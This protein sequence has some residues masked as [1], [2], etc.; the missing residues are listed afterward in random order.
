RR[1]FDRERASVVFGA[2]GGT[3]L[4]MAYSF[5]A[6]FP[7]YFGRLPS[8]LDE[9]LP[10]LTEDSFAGVL[11][12]VIAGRI[13]NRL[14]LG[15]VNFTIDAA[16]ASSLAALDA[17]CKELVAGSSDLV[18]CGGAD[19]HNGIY[20][21][22]MF[23][24][25]HALSPTGR[26]RSFDAAADGIA[27][28]EGVACVALKRLAD[29]E[30][31]GDRI[32]AVIDAVAGSSDGRSLG[33]TAPR[34]EGQRR[35]LERAY[36]A[37]GVNPAEVGLI[38]AHGTGTVV[39]DRT[40]LSALNDLFIEA[41]AA[42]ASCALGSVKSQIGHTKCAAGLAA[43]VKV[44]AALHTGVRPPTGP[45]AEP[46]PGWQAETSPFFFD[47]QARPWP[48]PPEERHAGVSAFGFGGTNFHAVLS[49]YGGA[50]QPAH[51]QEEWPAELFCLRG[52]DLAGAQA[53]AGRLAGAVAANDAAG[54]PWR[55]CDLAAYNAGVQ[56]APSRTPFPE[57]ADPPPAAAPVQL[58]FVAIN[59]DDLAA[60]LAAATDGGGYGVFGREDA[61]VGKVAFLFP[62]QGSQRPG[63]LSD[64]FVAFPRL[65]RHLRGAAARYA[66]LM[67]PPAAFTAP[68]RAAQRHAMTDTEV[69]QPVMGIGGL[70][71]YDL[72]TWL[73][74]SPDLAGGH[75]FG[76]MVAL[77]AAG[78][79]PAG[80][81]LGLG[82]ARAA[83]IRAAAGDDPGTMAAIAADEATVL[84]ALAALAASSAAGSVVIANLNA[85]D[86]TVI[87]GPA[88]AVEVALR[89]FTEADISGRQIPVAC[90]FHSPVV[91]AAAQVFAGALE[92]CPIG[93]PAYPVLSNTTAA[94]HHGEDPASIRTLLARQVAEPVRFIEQIEAMY[95][96]GARVFI[97]CGPGRVLTGL[98]AKIL[99]ERP[100]T[101]VAC[102]VS[103]EPGLTQLLTALAQLAV[104]GVAMDLSRLFASRSARPVTPK[105]IPARPGWVIDGHLTKT[106][107]GEVL[108]GGLRPSADFVCRPLVPWSV[109]SS[110]PFT[111]GASPS[112][113]L[114]GP[115]HPTIPVAA[116]TPPA[117][118]TERDA[119]VL[120]YFQATQNLIAANRDI[121]LSY[122]GGADSLRLPLAA[123]PATQASQLAPEETP[124]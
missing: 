80:E 21:Y 12:N 66:P 3:D 29:A 71:V 51:S 33:L 108:A 47:Q 95:A 14:D 5:R 58:A 99:G 40:E 86:Q 87:S 90:A 63:M 91:A 82:E 27:L 37:A 122:L 57:G 54:R 106:V 38:E 32:Y 104:A 121:M 114:A 65:H 8:E 55:L 116:D 44:A 70:A 45:I 56:G 124:A 98:V 6:L 109:R 107:A 94:P 64:L 67:F 50:P 110:G 30:R 13:A 60:K 53:A 84:A 18:L 93:A 49:G 101:A 68:A 118:T 23:A 35:A 102:D 112:G 25:A 120:A 83:A 117:G 22:L 15:G 2:E 97:E 69:A 20:D 9:H 96:A 39:G 36:A 123:A 48:A 85:P 4:E 62:G 1:P 28:G 26:C 41:G 42:A 34:A 19:L 76:E 113:P 89:G 46:N 81:L 105:S 52:A 43:V 100:H 115:W 103:G 77:A 72:L 61:G 16:C 59:L 92:D 119:A 75:S 74:I 7:S 73:G 11:A 111:G 17:A 10:A 79:I 31:D 78:A 24:S 88:A